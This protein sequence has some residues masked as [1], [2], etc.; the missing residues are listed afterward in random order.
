[1]KEYTVQQLAKIAGVSVRTLHHYDHIGLLKPASRNA[2]RYRFYGKSELLRLQ[3]I[4]F[5]RELDCSL[6]D[7]ARMLDS[8]GFDPVD[9]L[10]AHRKELKN[11]AERL[12]TLL[13]TIDKTIRKLK[14]EKIEMSD[15]ELYG[16]LSKEQAEAYAEE[17]RQRWDPKLVDETNARVKTWSKEKW[18]KVNKEIDEIMRQLAALMG[19]PVEDRKVQALVARHRAYLNNFYEVKPDMYRGL[20]KLYV[21]DPRFM[22]YFEKYRAGLADYLAQ[23]IEYYC[24]KK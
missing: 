24:D 5:F 4:L 15:E 9:A 23:A 19:T 11:R 6:E 14:G 22:A 2:A 18:T 8:P 17:A 13:D 21:E 16:G 10:E 20:G 3:Q 1:M 12:D 7:I